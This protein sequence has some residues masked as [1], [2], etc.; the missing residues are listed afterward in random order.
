M[1]GIFRFLKDAVLGGVV[2]LIPLTVVAVVMG[3][4]INLVQVISI[5]ISEALPL[6]T[7]FGVALENLVAVV[8]IIVA[9]ALA[10]MLAR[11][12]VGRSLYSWLDA[13]LLQRVP[14]Y[15]YLKSMASGLTHEQQ[16]ILKPVLVRF[17]DQSQIAFEVERTPE[18]DVVI[19]LPDA[20]EAKSG[21]VSMVTTDRVEPLNVEFNA[22]VKSLNAMGRGTT[23]LVSTK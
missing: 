21:S 7:V 17:D 18:G 13:Q 19:F 4:A 8:L 3:K 22:I 11:S 9:C 6:T 16:K 5:P 10:G 20:P 15:A 2:F 12:V 23:E 1:S 14:G